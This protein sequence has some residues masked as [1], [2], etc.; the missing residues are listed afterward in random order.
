MHL[1][2]PDLASVD[3][4]VS[5]DEIDA[6][7][8]ERLHFAPAQHDAGLVTLADDVVEGGGAVPRDELVR[9]RAF[10]SHDGRIRVAR[11]ESDVDGGGKV[12]TRTSVNRSTAARSDS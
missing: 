8:A 2:Q 1:P 6:S 3:R 7:I 5:I 11:V 10:R 9:I 12:A 4:G